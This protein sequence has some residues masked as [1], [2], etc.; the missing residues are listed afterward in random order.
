M[1]LSILGRFVLSAT[2]LLVMKSFHL[3][4]RI[5]LWHVCVCGCLELY[6]SVTNLSYLFINESVICLSGRTV[7]GSSSPSLKCAADVKSCQTRQISRLST[8]S[9]VSTSPSPLT[10]ARRRRRRGNRRRRLSN[11]TN[12]FPRLNLPLLQH[13]HQQPC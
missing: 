1:V 5:R 2:A 13:L 12:S 8:L 6:K 11:R 4:P 10:T 9:D 7:N 3:M